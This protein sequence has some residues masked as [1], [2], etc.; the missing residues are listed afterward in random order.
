M[1][2]ENGGITFLLDFTR[3][4]L[5]LWQ[6]MYKAT[7]FDSCGDLKREDIVV[8]VNELESKNLI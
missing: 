2:V 7:R 4:A 3:C 5:I 8:H 6:W 1:N